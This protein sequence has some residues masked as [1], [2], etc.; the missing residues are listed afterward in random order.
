MLM[1]QPP[2]LSTTEDRTLPIPHSLLNLPP[3]FAMVDGV[4]LV[5]H[6]VSQVRDSRPSP[7]PTARKPL[8]SHHGSRRLQC[9]S[10]TC[11]NHGSRCHSLRCLFVVIVVTAMDN[12]TNQVLAAGEILAI[13]CSKWCRRFGMHE[14][15]A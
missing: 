14:T 5:G 12:S 15:Q 4:I 6:L 2:F 13:F 1:H 11:S 10:T 3:P 8:H 7:T 9:R